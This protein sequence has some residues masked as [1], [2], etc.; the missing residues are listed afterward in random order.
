[1]RAWGRAI[2]EGTGDGAPSFVTLFQ[3]GGVGDGVAD[4][5]VA[6]LRALA[7]GRDIYIEPGKTYRVT[8]P[9]NTLGRRIFGPGRVIQNVTGG[10]V[11][12]NAPYWESPVQFRHFA[13]AAKKAIISGTALKI[14]ILGDSTATNG[15][16]MNV[17][18]QVIAEFENAGV[19]VASVVQDAV[20]ETAWFTSNLGTVLTGYGEQKHVV[21]CKFGINDSG[22]SPTTIESARVSLRN[23]MR[24]RLGEIRASTYGAA[25]NLSVVLIL[26]NALGNNATNASN[27]NNAWLETIRGIYWE[28]ARDYECVAYDPF[29]ESRWG[30]GQENESLDSFAVHPLSNYNLDIWTRAVRDI[31]EPGGNVGRNRAIWR[32][33]AE[34]GAPSV[35]TALS[36]YPRG[37]SWLR[38]AA[39][40][41]WPF[42]GLLATEVHPDTVG[43]QTLV[44]F[45]NAFPR[46][47]TRHWR[48]GA[49]AWGPWT[50]DDGAIDLTMVAGWISFGGA[51]RAPAV[52]RSADGVVSLMGAIKD[53]TTTG[54]TTITTL[55]AGFRPSHEILVLCGTLASPYT[56]QLRIQ[57]TGA[58]KIR[59]GGDA[60]GMFLDG[61][62]F[63]AA[64]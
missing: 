5:T 44:D 59:A 16:V 35:G 8:N 57:T 20:S 2:V 50:G 60:T 47:I 37:S 30:Q 45:T 15:Y 23:A 52:T 10:I 62:S 6:W 41:G 18:D 51:F 43:R 31:F 64:V 53:G 46:Q 1:M 12:L 13:H 11:Q 38:A 61:V 34:G 24:Q 27:R 26:P 28:A 63:V 14:V 21:F 36:F 54:E 48:T 49:V 40:D 4:D 42:S 17:D 33:L 32:T 55:P 19:G 58:V 7:D 3:F 25:A 39:A 22:S 29:M 9:N 56:A